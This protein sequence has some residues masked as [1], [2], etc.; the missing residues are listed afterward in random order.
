MDAMADGAAIRQST[1]RRKIVLPSRRTVIA[2]VV[3]L[4]LAFGGAL[5]IALPSSAETTDDAYIGADATVVAPQVRGLITGVLVKD[6][7]PVKAGDILVR[8]DAEELDASVAAARADLANA[9]GGLAS[10]RGALVILE[11]EE[12][13][14]V[15]N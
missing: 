12:R 11:A 4:A 2:S 1:A 8:I 9:E 6:N 5:W 10:A 15:A 14:A 13:L 7:Q 3:A